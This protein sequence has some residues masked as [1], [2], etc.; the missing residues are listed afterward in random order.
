MLLLLQP[1]VGRLEED[2]QGKLL[3][4]RKMSNIRRVTPLLI[5]SANQKSGIGNHK[6]LIL[7]QGKIGIMYV[8]NLTKYIQRVVIFRHLNAEMLHIRTDQ[9]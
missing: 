8:Q 9:I 2:L 4:T 5:Y 6:S 1:D 3:V 7:S